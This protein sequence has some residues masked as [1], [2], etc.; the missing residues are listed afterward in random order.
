MIQEEFTDSDLTMVADKAFDDLI[1]GVKNS[2]LNFHLQLSPFSAYI[3]VKKSLQKDKTGAPVVP[4]LECEEMKKLLYK[5]KDLEYKLKRT[6]N[7][8]ELALEKVRE[9]ESL[10]LVKSENE[11]ICDEIRILRA[12][13]EILKRENFQLSKRIKLHDESTILGIES[14]STADG[15]TDEIT[16]QGLDISVKNSEVYSADI[17]EVHISEI[18]TVSKESCS[19][20]YA[21]SIDQKNVS[22]LDF[23]N[24][25][26]KVESPCLLGI[27]R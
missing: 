25:S 5:N 12:G 26:C 23:P 1:N 13:N 8:L 18:Q 7:E 20:N 16:I 9:L 27:D 22:A 15:S 19:K 24:G 10:M 2:K 6:N 21:S 3:S 17:T 4:S 11:F 14:M